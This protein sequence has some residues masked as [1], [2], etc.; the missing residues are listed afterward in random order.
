MFLPATG[1]KIGGKQRRRQSRQ[2]D[3]GNA[4]FWHPGVRV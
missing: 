2:P 3:R 4:D 1:D